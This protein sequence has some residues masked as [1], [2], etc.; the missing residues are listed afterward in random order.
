MTLGPLMLDLEGIEL[1][2]TEKEILRHPLVGGL[3]YFSRNYESHEQIAALTRTVREVR[4]ELLICVDHEGG[5]VQRFREEFTRLPALRKLGTH[6]DKNAAEAEKESTE[7]AWLMAAELRDVDI[8]F[9]FAPVL[10][11]DYE[12][13]EVIG[14]R[15]F[16]SDKQKLSALA[17]AYIQGL[18]DAGMSSVGKHYPGHGYVSED[19][20]LALPVDSREEKDIWDNDVYPFAQLNEAGLLDAVMPAHVIYEQVDEKPAG[21]SSR[22]IKELL[23]ERMKFNGVVFSD[24]LNMAA[25]HVAGS[26]VDRANAAMVAGCDMILV[27]N[28]RNGAIEV[29]DRFQW[30]QNQQSEN[31]LQSMRAKNTVNSSAASNKERWQ[32]AVFLA[33]RLMNEE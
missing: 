9:S 7:L 33:E 27:C 12:R 3:I 15:A 32:R 28:N 25:A 8:D 4:K 24:D 31:R 22:W 29:I 10:D 1:D 5:R 16:H 17:K 26:F 23:R 19:S 18:R 13:C 11:I 30:M 2:Q 6:Y 21:F 14:D 20:H